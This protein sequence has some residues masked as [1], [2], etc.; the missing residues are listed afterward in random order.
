MNGGMINCSRYLNV[1][2]VHETCSNRLSIAGATARCRAGLF[3]LVNASILAIQVPAT[4][5]T[6]SALIDVTANGGDANGTAKISADSSIEI[7][8]RAY[9]GGVLTLLR[10]VKIE[11]G[12]SAEEIAAKIVA[13]RN[14]KVR[15][16]F[17]E[18]EQGE[19]V[20]LKLKVVKGGL[21]LVIR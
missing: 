18:N 9:Q 11:S 1:G 13:R 20:A 5:F 10:A 3:A 16:W 6:A 12:L 21:S 15:V 19:K 2:A 17:D 7:D 8:T 14:Q 4:G